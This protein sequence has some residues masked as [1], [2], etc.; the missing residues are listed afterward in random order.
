MTT[1]TATTHSSDLDPAS[2]E[3]GVVG[4]PAP[5][6][7]V[8]L[9]DERLVDWDRYLPR[10]VKERIP[11]IAKREYDEALERCF[12][13]S[14]SWNLRIIKDYFLSDM[15]EHISGRNSQPSHY[16]PSLHNIL[17]AEASVYAPKGSPLALCKVRDEF[18]AE[19][20]R[21]CGDEGSAV[22]TIRTDLTL[23]HYY[24]SLE[25]PKDVQAHWHME[26]AVSLFNNNFKHDSQTESELREMAL[27]YNAI[28]LQD[29]Q[30]GLVL[31]TEPVCE[32][33]SG[34]KLVGPFGSDETISAIFVAASKLA[35]GGHQVHNCVCDN[36]ST[37]LLDLHA[38]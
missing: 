32:Q 7:P 27:I 13:Y 4:A 15:V 20:E 19:A 25:Q 35:I 34:L 1:Q 28:L 6:S 29:I 16:S 37:P 26:R 2:Q 30:F 21:R 8:S 33:T 11:P 22:A 12:T 24:M 10:A 18:V 31:A 36:E 17:I 38:V 23:A 5:M 14:A 9:Q 3:S